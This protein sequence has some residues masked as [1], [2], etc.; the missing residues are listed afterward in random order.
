MILQRKISPLLWYW[1]FLCELV[2]LEKSLCW[3]QEKLIGCIEFIMLWFISF[4]SI[5]LNTFSSQWFTCSLPPCLCS[6]K[7]VDGILGHDW[8]SF[9]ITYKWF[10]PLL[11][12]KSVVPFNVCLFGQKNMIGCDIVLVLL[13]Y[14]LG[15]SLADFEGPANSL[16]QTCTFSESFSV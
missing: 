6:Y 13:I 4:S 2:V 3:S 11:V 1:I 16:T 10:S 9:H 15:L 8:I 7:L 12:F 5:G 14:H